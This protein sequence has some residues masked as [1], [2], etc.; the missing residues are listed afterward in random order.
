MEK[1]R[2]PY[3]LEIIQDCLA[4]PVREHALFCNLEGSEVNELNAIRQTALY[5]A[6]AV[7][8]VQGQP[9]R[10]VFI[11][12]G[13]K[14]KLTSSSPQG[15]S[16]IVRVA[17]TGEVLGLSATVSETTYIATAETLEP[18]QINFIPQAEFLAFLGGHADVAL[19]VARHLSMELRRAYQQIA[20]VVLSPT[21]RARFAGLLLNAASPHGQPVT[22]GARFQL[23]FTHQEIGE[24]IGVSRETVSRMFG[25]FREEGRILH[26]GAFVT[27]PEPKR[28]TELLG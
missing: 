23:K 7:L 15:R 1:T 28:L 27:I 4:C 24:I 26:R 12:C 25:D 16:V 2:T 21:A 10:G 3:G 18:T 6:G 14:V 19:R 17:D 11:I 8:F 9:G 22:P 20:Q 5:P 13:G